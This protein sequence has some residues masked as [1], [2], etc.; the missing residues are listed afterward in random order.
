MEKAILVGLQM[1]KSV[2]FAYLMAELKGLCE[3][4]DV[5]VLETVIQN[6]D[7]PTANLYIGS[8]KV[9][10]LKQTV[11]TLGA[12]MVI[13]DD[14]LSA[15]QIRNLEKELDTKV[16]DR[17]ILIL[18]IFARRARTREAMLQVELAQCQYMLPRSVGLNS[19]FS[20]QKSGTGSKGPGEKQLELDKRILK[21]RIF[22]LREDLKELVTVRRTQREK[23]KKEESFTVA[24]AG[25]TNSGKSSILNKLLEFS[26]ENS[27]KYVFE[28]N[29]LFAT[30]ETATRSIT[31]KNNH[32][33]LLTDTVG[34]ISK[35][36]HHLIE[37]FKSTLEEIR[38]ATLI[39]HIIDASN[40]E[41]MKQIGVVE[42][43]LKSL[44]VTDVPVIYVF[45]KMD[46]RTEPIVTALSPSI[47]ISALTGL[48][49]DKLVK[50]I[51]ETLHAKLH[52]YQMLIPFDKGQIYSF[53][54][55]NTTIYQ[56]DYQNDGIH[57]DVEL[58]DYY[59]GLYRQYIKSS[60]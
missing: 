46:L 5:E 43:V 9:V 37:A 59:V 38:E 24:I 45:N 13:F 42:E 60:N 17:T 20:R 30:L 21:D 55:E 6:V 33:F 8:G 19:G 11:I 27:K 25:Y 3:A 15:T 39:L 10:E 54:K 16:I 32:R 23:R 22:K 53:L 52:R 50:I 35:L 31:L 18:D 48:G 12:D 1:Q 2:D 47:E 7:R 26:V 51:D 14:E 40:P 28:K 29:M 57:V 56:T 34:F 49:C 41:F 58:N 4:C 44:E 36:P